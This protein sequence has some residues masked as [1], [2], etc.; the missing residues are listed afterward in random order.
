MVWDQD[1]AASGWS[2]PAAFITALLH[3][4]DWTARWISAE[5]DGTVT[6][7]LEGR[8]E[9]TPHP[10]ALPL[11]RK[12]FRTEKRVA[13]ALLFVSGLGQYEA[14]INGR[15]ITTN[16]LTPGWTD[17]RKRIF[18]NSYDVTARLQAGANAIGVML[19]NGMYNVEGVAGRYTK[20]VGSDGQ[21]KLILQ[22]HLR[23][24]DGT[25]AIIN[26]DGSWQ[27][28]PGPIV[29]SSAYGGED[30][31]AQ[32]EPAGW[33]TAGFSAG[34]WKPAVVVGGPGGMLV[35][36]AMPPVTA[37]REFRPVKISHPSS[38]RVVYDLGQNFA[39]W[40]DLAVTGPAHS[41]V[42]LICG[43][44]LTADGLVTQQSAH[45]FPDSQ[46]SFTYTLKGA[47]IEHWHPRFSY[48]G[49]RYV[50][51]RL[52]SPGALPRVVA[53]R[54]MALHDDVAVSGHF[55]TSDEL[56]TRIHKLIDASI[57]S[58][59][60]S[61][62]TDCPHREKL[63][64]LEQTHLAAAAIMNNYDVALLYRKLSDDM[65]DA[66][67]SNGL[68]PSIAPEFVA[69]VD[70]AGQSTSFR[71]SPEWG[72]AAILSPWAAY[73]MYGDVE[74]LR[75]HY[76]SMKRYAAYLGTRAED[77][78]ISYGL[79]DWYDIGPAEPGVSQ[80]TGKSLTAT[81]TYY[82]DLR[83]L[84]Q[85]AALV[86]DRRDQEEFA[87]RAE[88]VKKSFNQRL[89]HPQTGEYDRGS[90]TAQAMPL[91]AGLVP[92]EQRAR[93]LDALVNDVRRHT[94]HVTAGDVGFHYVVRALTESERSDV[95]FDMLSRRDSPSYGYQ[96]ERGATA[97]TE[98]WDSNPA[99]SQ[100][101]FMLGHGEEWFY[102]GLAGIVIDFAA[103]TTEGRIR[104]QPAPVGNVQS[105]SATLE[106]SWGTVR[107]AWVLTAGTSE[108]ASL[109]MQVSVPAGATATVTFPAPSESRVLESGKP[110]EQARGVHAVRGRDCVLGS[111]EYHFVISMRSFG[112]H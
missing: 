68:I 11:F 21:P 22:L 13:E 97:L 85:I 107:S 33:D 46:N 31:D 27:T 71:D 42:P 19:G 64:W 59:L 63:G 74:L 99:S 51:A 56:F 105:A 77:G 89:F 9:M 7:T 45:A 15:P 101:H 32:L 10:K 112:R 50:E 106:T 65:Q 70:E 57:L 75:D 18:Y 23:Y 66:Q 49:F 26:S 34:D 39:G 67:L 83:A 81:A 76:D 52:S 60:V 8:G 86:G 109:Q 110:L 73:R 93:V 5:P 20:F 62:L 41:S 40:P 38:D 78:M 3:A 35:S 12:T 92:P 1:G 84:T 80:L 30:F 104:I 43:E 25:Q 2:K 91:V 36:E 100:N 47:G 37:A 48:Y 4:S 94:N 95:L 108:G 102:R 87:Q 24:A 17:Y 54:G 14:R 6:P 103:P 90:Q 53:L 72:S 82:E 29:F 28:R 16:V 61:V 98:A 44:L 111:G 69:F 58:N 55:H 88:A 96:L 79:G